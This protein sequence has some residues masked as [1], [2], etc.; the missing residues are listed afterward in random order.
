[1]VLE[2]SE[3]MGAHLV[4]HTYWALDLDYPTSVSASG[5]PFGGDDKASFPVATQVHYEFARGGREPIK[6]S[7]YDGGLLPRRPEMMPADAEVNPTG[8][9]IMVGEKGVLVYDTYGHN[10]RMYPQYLEEEYANTPQMLPRI[11][12]ENHEMNLGACLYGPR[13]TFMSVRIRCPTYRN[14]VAWRRSTVRWLRTQ[15]ILGRQKKASLSTLQ[16]PTS[17]CIVNTAAAGNCN[18]LRH[19]LQR[20]GS[21]ESTLFHFSISWRT[22]NNA[23]SLSCRCSQYIMPPNSCSRT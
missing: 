23:P 7:W 5:S 15:A 20:V 6:V 8:G 18:A 14:H 11:P 13:R 17:T 1:M 3:T 2:P 21:F 22:S 12:D 9:A 16:M 4:D 19:S 10:P